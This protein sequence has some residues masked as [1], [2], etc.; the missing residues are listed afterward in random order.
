MH[1]PS[2]LC[3]Y[4]LA[5]Y[6][7]TYVYGWTRILLDCPFFLCVYATMNSCIYSKCNNLVLN[8]GKMDILPELMRDTEG[9]SPLEKNK[10]KFESPKSVGYTWEN[11][12]LSSSPLIPD[13]SL[14]LSQ[15]L[16]RQW[17]AL[18]CFIPPSSTEPLFPSSLSSFSLSF[19]I[20]FSLE[21][22]LSLSLTHHHSHLTI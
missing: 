3:D 12:S 15:R 22:S 5:Y 18:H 1:L 9:I 6:L 10:I 19:H 16:L 21:V 7:C 2:F 14:P 13:F 17:Q 11:F 4:L 8:K 20:S